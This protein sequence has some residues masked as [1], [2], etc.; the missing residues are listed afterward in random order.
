MRAALT[1]RTITVQLIPPSPLYLRYTSAAASAEA[2]WYAGGFVALWALVR[3]V[4]TPPPVFKAASAVIWRVLTG[5]T[6]PVLY[7]GAYARIVV[8]QCV[9]RLGFLPH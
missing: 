3:D 9:T 2:V 5:Q 8:S 7:P 4:N 6:P 1:S